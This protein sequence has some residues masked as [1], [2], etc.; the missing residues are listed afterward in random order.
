LDVAT[1]PVVIRPIFKGVETSSV[2]ESDP[3]AG[4]G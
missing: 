3:S 2:N 4:L 1:P